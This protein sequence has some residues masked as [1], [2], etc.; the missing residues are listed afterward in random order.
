M[1]TP[2]AIRAYHKAYYQRN[3]KKWRDD[4]VKD[5]ERKKKLARERYWMNKVGRHN[6]CKLCPDCAAK[7][8]GEK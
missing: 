5:A 7:V 3:K 8:K 2:E 4:Y 6:Y 1:M